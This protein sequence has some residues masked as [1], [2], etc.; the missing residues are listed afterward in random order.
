[1]DDPPGIR[2]KQNVIGTALKNPEEMEAPPDNSA[3]AYGGRN[4]PN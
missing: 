2:E 3:P 4:D 1:M